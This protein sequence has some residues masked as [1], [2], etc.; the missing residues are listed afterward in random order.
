MRVSN[1]DKTMC[2]S[3][4][5]LETIKKTKGQGG[6][7][8]SQ[9]LLA[10][11]QAEDI[12]AMKE[13]IKAVKA[14]I[15]E[16]KTDVASMDSKLDLLIKQSENRPLLQII[17]ELINTKGLWIVLALIVIGIWGIDISGLKGLLP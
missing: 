13:E 9:I 2:K 15:A 8:E 11:A 6:M 12:Q 1:K 7:S 17:K 16:L 10:E 5:V 14:D 4:A 3:I